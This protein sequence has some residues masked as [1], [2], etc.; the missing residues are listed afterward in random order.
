MK[1]QGSSFGVSIS[2]THP[3]ARR[4]ATLKTRMHAKSALR[5]CSPVISEKNVHET[6]LADRPSVEKKLWSRVSIERRCGCMVGADRCAAW[7]L[8]VLFE[9]CTIDGIGQVSPVHCVP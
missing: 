3:R 1:Y 4:N 6:T 5:E 8:A 2:P 7:G 9:G